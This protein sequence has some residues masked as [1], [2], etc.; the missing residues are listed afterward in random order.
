MEFDVSALVPALDGVP[1]TMLWAL[2]NR[3]TEA[4][5]RDGVLTDPECL[6]IYRSLAYDFHGHFGTPTGSLAMRAAAIDRALR[7]WLDAHPSGFVVSLGE[8]LETQR[9]RVDN[10]RMRWL[11]VDLPEAIRLRE[12][13]MPPTD[14]CRHMEASALDLRWMNAVDPSQGV[15]I[16]A[17]GL[18]MYLEPAGVRTLLLS[19][20]ERFP[21]ACL[22]F[23]V[24]P[25]WFS[26]M[27][28]RGLQK[29]AR[30]RLPPMPWGIDRD[31][32]R[33][34]LLGWHPRLS[35]V[36]F[37]DY[38]SPR[39]L[40]RLIEQTMRLIPAVRH[41][42]PSLVQVTVAQ[43]AATGAGTSMPEGTESTLPRV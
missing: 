11:S 34:T 1:E 8:G 17:Q 3:A 28:L 41:G 10:G 38:G 33:A 9:G 23:D 5:R 15:F 18:L 22:V 4:M 19:I 24:V 21:G 43:A 26:R 13:F 20:A 32:L 35:R 25:K 42:L 7:T 39:G 36:A 14:R 2:H 40:P 31:E 37:L 29:T 30:Y 6:R 16:V 27:T 12:Q